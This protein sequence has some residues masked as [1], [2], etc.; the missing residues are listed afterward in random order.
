MTDGAWFKCKLKWVILVSLWASL[1]HCTGGLSTHCLNCKPGYVLFNGQCRVGPQ[2]HKNQYFDENQEVSFACHSSYSNLFG[3]HWRFT[4]A[5]VCCKKPSL[6]A[7]T[8]RTTNAQTSF[9]MTKIILQQS[10]GL[11]FVT[12]TLQKTHCLLQW[13]RLL[14]T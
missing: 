12:A 14:M 2:C 3:L 4:L 10:Q 1:Y 8:K 9:S 11:H 6:T 5:I 13:P 7:V